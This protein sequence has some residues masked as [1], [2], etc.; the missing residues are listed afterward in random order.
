MTKLAIA[1]WLKPTDDTDPWPP[2]APADIDPAA[3]IAE[4]RRLLDGAYAAE[5]YYAQRAHKAEKERDQYATQLGGLSLYLCVCA[6]PTVP[7]Q[8]TPIGDALAAEHQYAGWTA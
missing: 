3:D 5:A 4:M 8:G 1:R 2:T 6:T 7:P